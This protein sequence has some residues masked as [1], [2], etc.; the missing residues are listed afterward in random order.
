MKVKGKALAA[1]CL[2]VAV[3]GV[4]SKALGQTAPAPAEPAKSWVDEAKN[5]VPWLKWG[6]DERIRHEYIDNPFFFD[7]DPPGDVWS[8][9]RLRSRAWTTITPAQNID[10]NTRLTWEARHWDEPESREGWD[11]SDVV[12]DNLNVRF[13]NL[14]GGNTTLTVGRQ[15]IILG[16]GW[17]VLEGTPLD[18]SRTIY[19]DAAR[20]TTDFKDA[21]TA[22]DLIYVQQYSDPDKW[23][24]PINSKDF[25]NI[26]QDERGAIVWLTNK[27]IERTEINPYFI[28][29]HDERVLANGDE[30]DIYTFGTRTVHA[31]NQNWVGRVEGAYQFGNR[32]NPAMFGAGTGDDLSAFGVNSRL[33]YNFNDNWKNALFVNYEFLSGDDPDSDTNE[34]FDPLWGRWPQFSELYVYPYA[35]E[36]RIAETTNLHRVGGGW[37]AS[38]IARMDLMATYNALFADENTLGAQA[39][40]SESGNFRGQL[41]T[42]LV[43][44]KFNRFLAGHIL[45][46]H[47]VPGNYYDDEGPRN[48]DDVTFLRGEIVITF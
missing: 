1:A 30:S 13:S 14:A 24:S 43:R 16:D 22:V 35:T 37:Q 20:L 18:G 6:A 45:A 32:E 17:L 39:G 15:D 3:L 9:T 31:F 29:K 48:D 12:W 47:F 40:F 41:F 44:Y 26:E 36:T 23:L 10:V 34:Q 38:P 8:F 5:P 25:H 4:S 7:T 2:S 42:F 19:F 28:Y 33:T 11:W 46:E 27:S 21:K